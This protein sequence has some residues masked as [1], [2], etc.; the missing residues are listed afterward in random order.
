M[1]FIEFVLLYSFVISVRDDCIMGCL[2]MHQ[3][4]ADSLTLPSGDDFSR[5]VL[6]VGTIIMALWVSLS[7][8]LTHTYIYV[9]IHTLSVYP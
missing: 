5:I 7:L 3:E 8:S 2:E 9:Y 6:D 1:F 4:E